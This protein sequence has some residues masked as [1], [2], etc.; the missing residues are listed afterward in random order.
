MRSLSI[1]MRLTLWYAIVLLVGLLLF[2]TGLWFAVEHRLMG[3]VDQR[4]AQYVDGVRTVAEIEGPNATEAQLDEEMSEF[5]REI[6]EGTWLRVRDA[7]HQ[8]LPLPGTPAPAALPD[9]AVDAVPRYYSV[10]V[11][12]KPY[13]LLAKR[14]AS[15]GRTYDV[16][17]AGSLQEITD[18]LGVFRTLL[19]LAIPAMMLLA[20]SGAY[21]ISGR[22]LA[23]V[24]RITLAA[25]SIGVQN[26]SERLQVPNTGDELQRLSET[27]ND[28]LA[29]L[30]ASVKRI[31]QFTADASH[32]LRTPV[33]LIRTTAEL[34]LRRERDPDQ[35]RA[36]LREIVAETDRMAQ[37]TDDLLMLARSDAKGSFTV[38]TVDLNDV[39]GQIVRQNE[40]IAA[41]KQ[42][43]LT[44]EPSAESALVRANEPALRRLFII[45][46]DNALKH[47]PAAGAVS[48]SVHAID[49]QVAIEVKDSG[50]GIDPVDLPHIFE[51][52]YRAD[53]S[54]AGDGGAGL[55]LSIA[56][57]IAQAH[58]AGIRVKSDPG[59]G[60]VFTVEFPRDQAAAEKRGME[61]AL[62]ATHLRQQVDSND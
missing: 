36:A 50:E 2:G 32:E 60:S 6:P 61:A 20:C 12:G 3:A 1:R 29:R 14:T 40:A 11:R 8:L 13:R 26:L 15:N 5:A 25:R 22:A 45:L 46:I 35:Y 34:A 56:Q 10:A 28:M 33:S 47:T 58:S 19:L 23:P 37:F 18:L 59:A 4:L 7:Q 48:M 53:K 39:A 49:D 9:V 54:R 41:A 16:I 31:T 57:S 38:A 17:A 24:D 55:G 52:F 44:F 21:W 51:R 62:T 30:E 27:W 42:I 43:R